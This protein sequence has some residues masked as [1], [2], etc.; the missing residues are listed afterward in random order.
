MSET[1]KVAGFTVVSING[2]EIDGLA[3]ISVKPTKPIAPPLPAFGD[4][5]VS[6]TAE[7]TPEQSRQWIE[8]IDGLMRS[9]P[10]YW[11]RREAHKVRRFRQ[12]IA[13]SLGVPNQQFRRFIRTGRW[14]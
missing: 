2:V 10:R 14:T 11:A 9:R 6:F 12:R 7:M 5:S 1:D 13:R 4:F 8:A 3:S